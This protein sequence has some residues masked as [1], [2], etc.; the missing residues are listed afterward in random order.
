MVL[1]RSGRGIGFFAGCAV[2][3]QPIE[4]SDTDEDCARLKRPD[5]VLGRCGTQAAGDDRDE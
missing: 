5:W 4:V 3:P 2:E 1:G